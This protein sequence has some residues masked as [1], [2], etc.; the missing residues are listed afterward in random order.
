M[1][2]HAGKKVALFDA[3]NCRGAF[4]AALC[5]LQGYGSHDFFEIEQLHLHEQFPLDSLNVA[6]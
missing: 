5:R 2:F 3:Q 4:F 1:S 6:F